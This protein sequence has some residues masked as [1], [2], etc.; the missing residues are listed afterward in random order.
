VAADTVAIDAGTIELQPLSPTAG[1]SMSEPW[2][3]EESEREEVLPAP[4]ETEERQSEMNVVESDED[5][6][7]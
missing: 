1:G 7:D 2:P 6:D 5:W 3:Q 4:E